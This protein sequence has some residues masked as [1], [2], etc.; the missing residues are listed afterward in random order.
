[1]NYL[2][3][4]RVLD[5]CV[6]GSALVVLSPVLAG[7]ALAIRAAGPGPAL[8]R[9]ARLGVDGGTFEM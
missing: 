4:K 5:I 1:M 6:S 2:A 7:I 9:S 3:L 8:Y